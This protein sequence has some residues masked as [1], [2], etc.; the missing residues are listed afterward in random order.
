MKKLI[1]V[2]GE[3]LLSD[4]VYRELVNQYEINRLARF[5]ED[6]PQTA[7]LA[8][9]L[10]DD[11]R[12]S[13]YRM[14][15]E[16]LQSSGLPWLSG[17]ISYDEGIVGPLVRPGIPGCAQCAESRRQMAGHGSE[18]IP[19][20]LKLLLQGEKPSGA[21]VSRLALFQMACLIAAEARKVLR[22][23]ESLLEGRI[24][25]IDLKTL[26]SS[27]HSFLP[28]PFC[29]I[30]GWLPDDS[31]EA[32]RIL[33]RPNPKTDANRYRCKSMEELKEVLAIHY[34]DDRSGLLNGKTAK[35]E[36]AFANVMVNL[37]VLIGKDILSAGRTHSYAESERTAI[38]E[39]LERYCGMLPRGKRTVVHD[40][41]RKLA[42]QALDPVT[43]GVHTEEQYALPDF[44]LEPFDPDRPIDWVWGY[45]FLQERPI[46]V[47]ES[48]AYYNIDAG[49][50]YVI[51]TSNGC[52]LGGSLEE[53]ILYGIL[54]VA[55]RDSFL[56]T[57]Y[58][59]L[60]IPRLDPYS[61]G[62]RE[63][64]L[65][66]DR[67][68]AVTGYDIYLFNSTME[69]GIPSIW[70]LA[71][72]RNPKGANVFCAAAAHLD[73]LRAAK[74][75]IHELDGLI[76]YLGTT[77]ETN[78]EEIIRMY[79]DPSLVTEMEDHPLLYCAPQA[80]ERLR[81]LLDEHRP[82][83]TF[84][85]EFERKTG[86]ADLTDDLKDVLQKFRR[87]NL[88]VIVIDQSTPETVQNGLYC[89][90]VL[91]PG[92]LPMTFGHN[93]TRLAGL[94]R[95]LKVPKELGY[96]KQLLSIGQLNPHPHPFH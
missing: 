87:L 54:E 67:L 86:H 56:M 91:I 81:F 65:M 92:M 70:A 89:A 8:L 3:G 78:R 85:E 9:L 12:P 22:G 58:G 44:P 82:L 76:H 24:F 25:L 95:V 39:G 57:W 11:W 52:A 4:F 10:Y 50:R 45:S 49:D 14:A 74:S 63:L 33:L 7:Q 2:I 37:P 53:A 93:F 1:T 61:A 73:P 88:D 59:R 48:L 46:L 84:D 34:L 51:E 15:E 17:F 71:K 47:P 13:E 42:E 55:E 27:L 41:Y 62:D 30:C 96:A 60:P 90:K 38:L 16:V 36:S 72:N 32:A 20:R 64:R 40:N 66:I 80:E 5:D 28:D 68:R 21:P 18:A 77:F 31:P 79:S 43:V 26:K 83:R 29:Q 35:L 23:R 94:E 19:E 69:N 75:A 6:V